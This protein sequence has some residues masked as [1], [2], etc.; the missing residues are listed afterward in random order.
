MGTAPIL[1]C[2]AIKKQP[3]KIKMTHKHVWESMERG[4][5]ELLRK[6]PADGPYMQHLRKRKLEKET[7]KNW[8]N[9]SSAKESE[10]MEVK[11][12][13]R[14]RKRQTEEDKSKEQNISYHVM[15]NLARLPSSQLCS[16]FIGEKQQ[17]QILVS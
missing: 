15:P 12:K 1:H 7:E 2:E 6:N 9:I 5:S 16:M 11:E 4:Y 8:K 3:N 14:D 17:Q 13:S 10:Q